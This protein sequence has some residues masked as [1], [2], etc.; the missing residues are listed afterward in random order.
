VSHM[1]LAETAWMHGDLK[2]ALA[3]GEQAVARLREAGHAGWLATLLV[4]MGTMAWLN[5][6]C[7]RGEGWSA[8][9]VALNRALGN[10]WIIANHLSDLG[11]VAQGRGD[12]VE[13]G[14]HYAES[15]CLFRDVGD[16]WYIASP[17]AGLAAIAVAHGQPEVAARLLGAAAA[18][19]E[20]SGSAAWATEQERDEHTVSAVR[21][22][23][24]EESY[25][26]AFAEGRKLPLEQAMAEAI[27]MV[28][29]VR[30][31]ETPTKD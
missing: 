3:L 7:E 29:G 28:D 10:R 1:L 8:E 26:S 11:L 15:T 6:D 17:L 14:R 25:A 13:T 27:A 23:L 22:T 16:T 12:L 31:A 18:L 20:S 30:D 19:R 4:D 2:Q 21:V 24:G 9:G 5:G